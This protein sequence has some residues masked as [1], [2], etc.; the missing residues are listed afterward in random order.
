MSKTIGNIGLYC[1]APGK[2]FPF[3]ISFIRD[4]GNVDGRVFISHVG[5]EKYFLKSNAIGIGSMMYM[6]FNVIQG[7]GVECWKEKE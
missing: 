1:A 4:N 7:D 6:V 3:L 5:D 2:Y